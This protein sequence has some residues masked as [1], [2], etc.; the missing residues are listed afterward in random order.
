M[1]RDCRTLLWGSAIVTLLLGCSKPAPPPSATRLAEPATTASSTAAAR[2]FLAAVA[3]STRA[4]A[5]FPFGGAERT[6]WAFVPKVRAGLP[7]KRMS[8]EQRT[9][10]ERLLQTGLSEQGF[11]TASAIIQHETTLRALEQRAGVRGWERRDP[12]LYYLAIF[13]TPAAEAPWGWRFE[14]HHLSVNVTSM[15]EEQT[16]TPLFMGA[17]PARVPSGPQAGVRLLAAEEDFARELLAMFDPAQRAQAIIANTTFGEIVTRN[18]P[19]V[20]PLT[21]AGL[22]A[23]AMNSRQQEQLRRLLG[24][25]SRRMPPA[26]ARVQMERME[27]AGFGRLHFAWAGTTAPGGPH[28]Y[29]IHGPTLLVEYDNTQTNANHVHTV[30]RDLTN[31]FGGD[32]LRKHYAR[33]PHR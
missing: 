30:W 18:D 2:N 5:V 3:D 20:R 8:P 19:V 9:T 31:D 17:N 25:Y 1:L 21:L 10:A 29:R 24:V 22:P 23:S 7:L 32:L 15:G 13:G 6:N 11:R 28:Y 4:A 12:G 14:G 16:V 33:H 27:A 26:A